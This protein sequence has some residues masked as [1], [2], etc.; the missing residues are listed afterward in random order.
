[1]PTS[2]TLSTNRVG[3]AVTAVVAA[4]AS[5]Y[6]GSAVEVLTS[7]GSPDLAANLGI[8]TA[9]AKR[10][11]DLIFTFWGFALAVTITGGWTAGLLAVAKT[12][13]KRYGRKWATAW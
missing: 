8:A 12:L 5:L 9:T 13:A 11:I 10:A 2:W 4:V 1:M 3:A 6:M 7:A